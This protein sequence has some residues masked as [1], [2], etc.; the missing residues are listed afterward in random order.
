MALIEKFI[1]TRRSLAILKEEQAV[2]YN[3]IQYN[4]PFVNKKYL[5]FLRLERL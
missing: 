4:I 3:T 1:A 2:P 5:A